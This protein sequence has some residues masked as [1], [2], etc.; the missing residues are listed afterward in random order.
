[1]KTRE[2]I[3]MRIDNLL[4]RLEL[5]GLSMARRDAIKYQIKALRWVLGEVL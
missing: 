2:E 3:R 1:M 4:L 5:P